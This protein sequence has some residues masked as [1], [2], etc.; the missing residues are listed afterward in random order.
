MDACA[1]ATWV[2]ILLPFLVSIVILLRCKKSGEP[3]HPSARYDVAVYGC[4][5]S[6]KHKDYMLPRH[7]PCAV[8]LR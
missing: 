4:G 2:A 5:E 7:G 6:L 8:Q 3:Y 1:I